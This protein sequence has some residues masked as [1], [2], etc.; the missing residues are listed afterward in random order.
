MC[1]CKVEQDEEFHASFNHLCSQVQAIREGLTILSDAFIEET[2]KQSK[3]M[4]QACVAC[5]FTRKVQ[6]WGPKCG[7][8][9]IM[10]LLFRTAAS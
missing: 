2:G 10:N 8:R 4:I 6:L 1:K 3:S 9:F 5:L 7:H